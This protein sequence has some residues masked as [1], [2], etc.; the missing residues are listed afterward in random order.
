MKLKMCLQHHHRLEAMPP[1]HKTFPMQLTTAPNQAI[2]NPLKHVTVISL[3][4]Q[5]YKNTSTTITF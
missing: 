4:S 2:I 1:V 5:Q 3:F